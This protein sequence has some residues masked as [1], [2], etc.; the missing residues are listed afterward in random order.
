MTKKIRITVELEVE[1]CDDNGN[2]DRDGIPEPTKEQVTDFVLNAIG[3][4]DD[5]SHNDSNFPT[6]C[7][8]LILR[9]WDTV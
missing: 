8:N 6:S 2:T 9:N 1:C 7:D 3:Y 4:Y 5:N